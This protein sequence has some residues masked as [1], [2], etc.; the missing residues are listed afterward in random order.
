MPGDKLRVYFTIDT[1]TPMGVAWRNPSYSPNPQDS[2]QVALLR[3]V[4]CP[5]AS[6]LGTVTH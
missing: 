5:A 2:H 4:L 1:E 6:K 3:K